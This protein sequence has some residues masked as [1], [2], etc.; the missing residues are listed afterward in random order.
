M[1]LTDLR[2]SVMSLMKCFKLNHSGITRKNLFLS[3]ITVLAN[4][5]GM[6]E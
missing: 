5:I 4:Q 6:I 3:K 1:V 2:V